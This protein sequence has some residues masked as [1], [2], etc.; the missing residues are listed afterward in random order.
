[1]KRIAL[2]CGVVFVCGVVGVWKLTDIPGDW[3]GDISIVHEYV[4]D[5]L[6][7]LWPWHYV[8]SAGPLY[9]Y[10][11]APGIAAIGHSYLSYK[12]M[13]VAVGM[14]GVVATYV[15][16]AEVL[17][18][19]WGALTAL[20]AGT[21]F[22]WLVWERLGNSQIFIVTLTS[23]TV[24]FAYRWWKTGHARYAVLGTV[25]SSL[26]LFVYPQ[27]WVL[28]ILFL[29]L[30]VSEHQRVSWRRDGKWIIT[31][32]CIIG[33]LWYLVVFR[34]AD[35]FSSG[36]LGSKIW[37]AFTTS[38]VIFFGR[39]LRYAATTA[40]MLHVRG[41]GVFRVNVPGS[42]QLDVISGLLFLLGI[43]AWIW[44]GDKKKLVFILLPISVLVL[45]SISPALPE[46]EIPNSGRTIGILP[47]VMV[48][49]VYGMKFIYD[50]LSRKT[51]SIS[52]FLVIALTVF[53]GVLNLHKYF[54]EY[55]Q[56][57][58]ND[59]TPY[60]RVVAAYIDTIPVSFPV[61]LASCCWGGW[62]QPE[63]KA[64]YYQLQREEKRSNLLAVQNLQCRDI[65]RRKNIIVIGRPDDASWVT[66]FYTCRPDAVQSVHKS[67]TGQNVFVSL[68]FPKSSE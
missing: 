18:I 13:S 40:L 32:E 56:G 26:G 28:P 50:L 46:A 64:I 48:C 35:V 43:V 68:Y 67:G 52:I 55:P 61:Y 38:P 9:H 21:S 16:A 27:T 41:D 65:D 36:Y 6:A 10:L 60:A 63:P 59:N 23:L 33:I 25:I 4:R 20:V 53:V 47:F 11:I 51:K 2:L 30:T 12:F 1:M 3:Y 29:L 66:K 58:P 5:V 54:M 22:W 57:L 24:W 45:P 19:T 14:I 37:P 39:L 49:V 62:G 7:G 15:L 44:R 8:A 34:S 42:P 17:G 31:T